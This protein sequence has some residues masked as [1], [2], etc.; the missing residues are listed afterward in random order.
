[1]SGKSVSCSTPH[2]LSSV[3]IRLK[4]HSVYDTLHLQQSS[5]PMQATRINSLFLPK[6]N[7]PAPVCKLSP[8][9]NQTSSVYSFIFPRYLSQL[10]SGCQRSSWVKAMWMTNPVM[11]ELPE[12]ESWVLFSAGLVVERSACDLMRVL[13]LSRAWSLASKSGH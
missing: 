9:S 2:F 11:S 7:P 10:V 8:P 4:W 5:I 13:C 6:S 1:M 12:V 3:T